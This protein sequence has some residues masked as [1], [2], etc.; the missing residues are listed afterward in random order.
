MQSYIVS[1]SEFESQEKIGFGSKSIVYKGRYKFI[2]VA[3]KKIS[4]S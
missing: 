3:I 4:L 1:P 2:D